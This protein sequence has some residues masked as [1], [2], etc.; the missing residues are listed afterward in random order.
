MGK[1]SIKIV[2]IFFVI[3]A[4]ALFFAF[5]LQQ[6]ASLEYIKQQHN[7]LIEYYQN[8]QILV[9]TVFGIA[10]VLITALS[11][12]AATIITLLGGALFGFPLG[13]LV[14]SFASTIGATCAFLMSR[15]LFRDYIQNKYSKQLV[16][17]NK[18]FE[19]EGAFYIFA[20]RLVPAFPF[21]M[22]NIITALTSIRTSTFYWVSQVGML[23]GTAVYVYAGTQLAQ[24]ESLSDIAS[25]E[26]IIAFVIL[27]V[28]PLVAKKSLGVL[29]KEKSVG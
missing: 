21:F 22:I 25:P 26:L 7:T 10:Y 3:I 2:L 14:V 1:K 24:I 18:G 11:L 28:F 16:K 8:N 29:R 17:I 4:I 23:P 19:R 12:P 27:G 20:L 6:Y 13:L 5:D 9:L 15:F